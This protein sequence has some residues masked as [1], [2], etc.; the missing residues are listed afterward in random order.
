MM[1]SSGALTAY[2]TAVGHV[3]GLEPSVPKSVPS[4]RETLE[5]L[6]DA[7]EPHLAAGPCLVWQTGDDGGAL[8]LRSAVRRARREGLPDPIPLTLVTD[9]AA[10]DDEHVRAVVDALGLQ[11]W[12]RVDATDGLDLLGPDAQ[13]ALLRHGVRYP[14][15]GHVV[16]PAARAA[17]GGTLVDCHGL[18]EL[19]DFWRGAPARWLLAGVRRDRRTAAAAAVALAPKPVRRRALAAQARA[20]VPDHVKPP[21]RDWLFDSFAEE[22]VSMP[23]S[24]SGAVRQLHRRRCLWETARTFSSVGADHGATVVYFFMD[25][26][27]AGALACAAGRLG[28]P[29]P[30][31]LVAELAPE[32]PARRT[33]APRTPRD[34]F[35]AGPESTEFIERWDGTGLDE[36][37]VHPER[38]R[39][40]WRRRDARASLLLQAAWLASAEEAREPPGAARPAAR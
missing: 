33:P 26:A 15:I 16:A 3:F 6:G 24:A 8:G 9:P 22:R 13:A 32:L 31:A 36:T 14:S 23:L 4:R 38:V 35:W 5:V 34:P 39:D 2:E 19:W 40:A 21:V 25:P 37:L 7:L 27:V 1:P 29:S 17:A 30:A 18:R 20:F 12:V 28:W 10:G 11:D